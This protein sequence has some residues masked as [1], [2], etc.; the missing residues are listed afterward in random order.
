MISMQY[1]FRAQNTQEG[2]GNQVSMVEVKLP[3]FMTKVIWLPD[4]FFFVR[5]SL[6]FLE[7][8][9][10]TKQQPHVSNIILVNMC[11]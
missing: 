8:F 5:S 2:N 1:P 6:D 4:I 3:R 11:W 7:M 9:S 10:P